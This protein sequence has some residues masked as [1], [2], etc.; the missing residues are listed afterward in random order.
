[1]DFRSIGL[2]A[3]LISG[4]AQVAAAQQPSPGAAAATAAAPSVDVSRLGLDLARINRGL[5]QAASASD[6]TGLN[7]RYVIDVYGKAPRLDVLDP[8]RDNLRYGPVPYG[9]PTHQQ[10]LDVMTPP[11]FRAPVMD[12]NALMRWLS[13]KSKQK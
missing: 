1:M 10:M 4:L 2:T 3:L 13:D 9:A 6:A 11:E 5:Q 12:F 8:K 7:L